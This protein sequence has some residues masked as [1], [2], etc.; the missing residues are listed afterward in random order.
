MA[1]L[2]CTESHCYKS[3]LLVQFC[4]EKFNV[5]LVELQLANPWKIAS[6]KGSGTHQT[7]IVELTCGDTVALGEAAPSFLYGESAAGVSQFLRQL[8]HRRLSFGDVD[9]SMKYLSALAGIPVAAKCALN[10]ALLDGAA[11][12]AGKSL[13]AYLGLG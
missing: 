5:R 6:S 2:N 11:K 10:L 7:V 1:A 8:D 4:M 3:V 9:G 12:L 13:N